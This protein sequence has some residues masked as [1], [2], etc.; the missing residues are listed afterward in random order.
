[1]KTLFIFIS[2]CCLLP[3]NGRQKTT[4][5][6]N[7]PET[8]VSDNTVPTSNISDSSNKTTEKNLLI[9]VYIKYAEPVNGYNVELHWM[10]F[11]AQCE[12]GLAVMTFRNIKTGKEFSYHNDDKYSSKDLNN[13]T[14]AKDFHGHH[15][16]DTYT[17]KYN[18]ASNY[19]D[20]FPNGGFGDSPLYYYAPFQFYDVDF[21]G[22]DELLINDFGESRGGN[23]YRIFRIKDNQLVPATDLP[24]KGTVYN[25]TKF[26]SQKQTWTYTEIDGAFIDV[27]YTYKKGKGQTVK[28]LPT[29]QAVAESKADEFK[30]ESKTFHLYSVTESLQNFQNEKDGTYYYKVVGDSL[31]L[32]RKEK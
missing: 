17:I 29:F 11:D 5:V 23:G 1:M 20:E 18:D 30:S 28:H 25:N 26:D 31:V 6:A 9:N 4:T 15:D 32:D 13:I 24:E 16:G 22:V 21:N 3:C 8:A 2:L 19:D 10:P 7:I 27:K 12:T 14:F